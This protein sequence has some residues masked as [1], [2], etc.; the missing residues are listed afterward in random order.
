[1]SKWS[2]VDSPRESVKMFTIFKELWASGGSLL[3]F[4]GPSAA[5]LLQQVTPPIADLAPVPPA[6]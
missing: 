1:M 6:V 5:S 3:L 2:R 4:M